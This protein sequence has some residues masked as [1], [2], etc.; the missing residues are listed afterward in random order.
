M[1]REKTEP[2]YLFKTAARSS[3]KNCGDVNKVGRIHSY[4]EQIGAINFGCCEL[5]GLLLLT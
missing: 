4:L 1:F 2:E 5:I 3:L